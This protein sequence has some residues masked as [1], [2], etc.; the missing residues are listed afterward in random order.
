MNRRDRRTSHATESPRARRI[1]EATEREQMLRARGIDPL[2]PPGRSRASAPR[3]RRWRRNLVLVLVVVLLSGC[4]GSWLLWQRVSAFNDEVSSAGSLSSALFFPLIGSD[5]VNVAMY[6]Y[7]GPEHHG[8]TYLADSII[9]LSIDP[10]TDTTT[11]IPIPRDLWIEGFP[12][13]PDNAKINEAFADGYVRG[14]VY[15]AGTAATSVLSKVTGLPIEHWMALDFTGF[16]AMVDSVGGVTVDN[17]VAFQYTWGEDKYFAGNWDGGSF[18]AGPIFLDGT[19]ALDYA[20]SR[21]TSVKAESSDFARS[22]RQ[23]RVLS[24]LRGKIGGGLGALGPGLAIMDALKGK[25]MA[26][27]LSAID[28]YLLSGHLGADRRIELTEGV[29]LE[30][31]SNSI[32][33]YILVVIGRAS[34]SDYAPLQAY[35]QT[36]LA[37]PLPSRSAS[38]SPS[39]P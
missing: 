12:E 15:E 32:G 37:R 1:R 24:A 3:R 33:Q 14:G 18:A 20:R 2:D 7:G 27:D 28:L 26:T 22:V 5:R 29:V 23:Q 21:Y 4:T 9:I 31:T 11:M 38:P 8:G 35:L 6:G 34:G 25:L 10:E 13:I 30:A 36:E 19:L 16:K 17:P 39:Q